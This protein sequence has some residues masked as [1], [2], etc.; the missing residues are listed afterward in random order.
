MAESPLSTALRLVLEDLRELATAADRAARLADDLF[1]IP[2]RDGYRGRALGYRHA[3]REIEK[4]I[5]TMPQLKAGH[6]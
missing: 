4:L 5:L 6:G 3:A 1:D 2:A